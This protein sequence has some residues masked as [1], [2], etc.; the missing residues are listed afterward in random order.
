MWMILRAPLFCVRLEEMVSA[1]LDELR[2]L[3]S[4]FCLALLIESRCVDTSARRE[5]QGEGFAIYGTRHPGYGN[6]KPG[7]AVAGDD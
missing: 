7:S 3:I 4:H 6:P 1:A 5:S 2:A